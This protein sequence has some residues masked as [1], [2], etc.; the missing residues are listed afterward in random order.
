MRK[1]MSADLQL[2]VILSSTR[3]NRRGEGFARWI[4]ELASAKP[5]VVAEL[6]DLKEWKL[7]NYE[8]PSPPSVL[9]KNYPDDLPRRWVEKIRALDGFVIVTP[10]Y[11]HGYPGSLKNAIDYVY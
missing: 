4:F 1:I 2:G 8:Y 7:P 6:L 10:E 3:Q 9:E 5:G 11:N